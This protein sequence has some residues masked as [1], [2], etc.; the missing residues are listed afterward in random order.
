MGLGRG[1][2]V[3]CKKGRMHDLDAGRRPVHAI[4]RLGKTHRQGKRDG[5]YEMSFLARSRS[6]ED[7]SRNLAGYFKAWAS[8]PTKLFADLIE[9]NRCSPCDSRPQAVA[10]PCLRTSFSN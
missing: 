1:Q 9:T 7:L 8:A 2:G 6:G 4:P 3:T 10:M 5:S